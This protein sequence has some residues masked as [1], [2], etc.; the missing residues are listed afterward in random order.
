M[1]SLARMKKLRSLNLGE[2]GLSSKGIEKIATLPELRRLELSQL[3]RVD[4]A[5]IP[6]LLAMERLE[7]VDLSGTGVTDEG[8]EKLT[9]ARNLRHIY[10]GGSKATEEGVERLRK[11]LPRSQVSWWPAPPEEPASGTRSG[12]GEGE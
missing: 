12:G 11:A 2:T 8:L 7:E 10:L 5:A 9:G 1:A 6:H 4:D 3:E